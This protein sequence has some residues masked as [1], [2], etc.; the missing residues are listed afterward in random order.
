MYENLYLELEFVKAKNISDKPKINI[1]MLGHK[2]IPSREGGVEVVVEELSVRM[3]ALGHNVT[4]LNRSGH[5]VAGEEYDSSVGRIY[6][7]VRLRTVPALSRRGYAAVSASFFGALWAAMGKYDVVHFHAEGP[8]ASMWIPKMFGKR[9]IAT[10][11]GLDHRRQKWGPFASRYIM[12]GERCAVKYADEI[13][14]LSKSAQKYFKDT[15]GRDTLLIPNGVN[16]PVCVEPTQ[17][18]QKYGLNK[19]DY[20]L[21]LGRLV[22]EKGL[23]YLIK[24]FKQLDTDK[25]LI[26][27]GGSSD[28]KEFEEKVKRL[29][30]DEPRIVFTGFVQGRTLAE[31]LSN[32]YMY[33]LP[34]DLEGMPLTLLEA[35]SYGQCCLVSDIP[36]CVDVVEDKA[37]SFHRGDVDD[38]RDKM[39]LLLRDEELAQKYRNGAGSFVCD[40]FNWDKV[41]DETI[42]AYRG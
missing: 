20:I 33:V 19:R 12:K 31:L 32:S 16:R 1:A 18:R 37:L 7:G 6:K 41:V 30:A 25:K 13:I 24:A 39:Q 8:C 34:S 14:V 5:H 35:M 9:C 17:I 23:E 4:C 21:Y 11:H 26:I 22:P 27:A 3:A 15:Y 38:L 36:E 2:R 10:I 29:A 42:K 28:I 40:K